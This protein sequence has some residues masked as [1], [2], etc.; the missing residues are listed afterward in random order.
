[1][2]PFPNFASIEPVHQAMSLLHMRKHWFPHPEE[3]ATATGL[4]VQR[5]EQL[6]LAGVATLLGWGYREGQLRREYRLTPG[7]IA[8]ARRVQPFPDEPETKAAPKRRRRRP[9][10]D[11]YCERVS[12]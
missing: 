9:F 11:D 6:L 8:A 5:V 4:P 3:L 2:P 10:P 1:M 12:A 7:Q